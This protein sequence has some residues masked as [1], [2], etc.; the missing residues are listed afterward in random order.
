MLI[1]R[2]LLLVRNILH[3]PANPAKEQVCVLPLLCRT[4]VMD[5]GGLVPT[6]FRRELFAQQSEI[7]SFRLAE[8]FGAN[9][10]WAESH[11][12]ISVSNSLICSILYVSLVQRTD[13]DASIHDQVLW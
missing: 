9:V 1:E 11:R 5:G 3:V 10:N 7:C 6:F 12:N 8:P 2:I 4:M 13:D